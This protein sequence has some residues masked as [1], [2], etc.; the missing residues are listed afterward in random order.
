MKVK[1]VSDLPEWFD[2]EKYRGCARFGPV[3]WWACLKE[4]ARVWAVVECLPPGAPA[5][6]RETLTSMRARPLAAASRTAGIIDVL[7]P[8]PAVRPATWA[9]LGR[10]ARIDRLADSEQVPAWRALAADIQSS[11]DATPTEGVLMIPGWLDK[12]SDAAVAIVNLSASDSVLKDAFEA[13]LAQARAA[14]GCTAKTRNRPNTGNW[15]DYGLLPFIDLQIW[16]DDTGAHIPRRIMRDAI[17][18]QCA[19]PGCPRCEDDGWIRDTVTPLARAL[20]RDLSQLRSLAAEN[21]EKWAQA[22]RADL[23]RGV[24]PDF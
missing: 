1:N 18:P 23:L 13:W 20:M 16:C 12:E 8:R 6:I 24:F 15:A 7:A 19:R 17:H 10:A 9:D 2:L 5:S 14:T 3:E 22:R 4:R 21:V 11:N